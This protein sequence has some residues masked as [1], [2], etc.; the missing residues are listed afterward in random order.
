MR[1]ER[2]LREILEWGIGDLDRKI[3]DEDVIEFSWDAGYVIYSHEGP[4]IG[5]GDFR[6]VFHPNV[7]C[8]GG[9][10]CIYCGCTLQ[11]D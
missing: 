7:V 11:F 9:G 2:T 6:G 4:Q 3:T 5:N 10:V 1:Y 8:E